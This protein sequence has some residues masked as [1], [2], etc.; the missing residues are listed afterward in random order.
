[1]QC[2]DAKNN[3]I[4]A[5]GR[6]GPGHERRDV[7]IQYLLGLGWHHSAG[8][9]IGGQQYEA[10]LCPACAKDERKR[11]VK[12]FSFDEEALPLDWAACKPEVTGEG[13]SSR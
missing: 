8:T 7:A 4:C 6:V 1:M 9:T 10:V 11:K 12:K 13:F 5:C 3:A 2:W